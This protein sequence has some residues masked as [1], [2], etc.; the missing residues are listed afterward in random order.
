[1]TVWFRIYEQPSMRGHSLAF[2]NRQSNFQ[3]A[4]LNV[5]GFKSKTSFSVFNNIIF[6]N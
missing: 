2:Q 4:S 1:M 6:Q 3:Q 5:E